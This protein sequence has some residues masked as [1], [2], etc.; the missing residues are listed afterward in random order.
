MNDK[1]TKICH[2]TSVHDSDD[3]RIFIKECSSI[4]KEGYE[5]YLVARGTSRCEN[6]VNIIGVGNAPKSR[7][8]R[9]RKFAK[10]IY[11]EA[12]S[13]NCDIYHFH[14][15][16]LLTI[17]KKLLKKGKKVI[18]DS[19]EDVPA[20][21]LD[22]T[23]IPKVFRYIISKLYRRYETKISKKLTAVVTATPYIANKFYGRAKKIVV[24]NNYPKLEDIKK[25]VTPFSKRES[26]ACY[27]GGITEMRGKDIMLKAID[28]TDGKLLLAGWNETDDDFSKYNNVEFLGAVSRSKINEIYEKSVIGLCLL[29]PAFN[30]VNSQPIK[31]YE[32]MAAGIPFICSDFPLWKKV[33][34]ST[35]AGICVNVEDISSI[36]KNI[37]YLFTNRDVAEKMGNAGRLAVENIY[38][39]DVEAKKLIDLYESIIG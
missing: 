12:L 1:K 25:T 9:G 14:D 35:N 24:I 17:G 4:A 28:G 5:T 37:E 19:H 34:E 2:M 20:Q 29:K 31:M 6:G 8:K 3:S 13:L 16:E 7:L 33:V 27:A 18:F 38:N 36:R 21:I 26:I 10:K 15:P 30:Y 23:Y 11:N 32:Y 39:W 22:K